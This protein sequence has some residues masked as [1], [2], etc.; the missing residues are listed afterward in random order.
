MS[1]EYRR[2]DHGRL[3]DFVAAAYKR[4]GLPS[5]DAVIAAEVMVHGDLM[6]IDSHGVAHLGTHFGYAPGLR[7]GTIKANPQ[8]RVVHETPSTA[9]IDGDGGLG[10]VVA[11]RAMEIAIAK[12]AQV[13]VGAVAVTNSRHYGAALHYAMMALPHDMIGISMTNTVP[14]VLPTF[15][16][17]RMLGT[18][19]ISVAAPAGQEPPFLLDMATS[20]VAGGKLE[21]AR[22]KGE[23]IP[24]GWAVDKDGKPTNDPF[25]TRQGGGLLPLGST[26]ELSSYKGYGLAVLVDIL[27]GV[28][29]GMGYSTMLSRTTGEMGHFF[30]AFRIDAF[31]PAADFKAMMDEMM[32]ALRATPPVEGAER[33]LVPGEKEAEAER[34]RLAKGIPLHP[35]VVSSLGK[36]ALEI[37]IQAE[38][39][40]LIS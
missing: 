18:N 9:L 14:S 12:A 32:R 5:E 20:V 40:A 16:R 26:P 33:V 24:F 4:L 35:D 25:V 19:P 15:G 11:H 3:R 30:A 8:I 23:L 36:L 17:E 39:Q 38:F 1:E 31:R 22:R 34:E 28:L 37:D 7:N 29:S 2:F 27:C 10:L 6:G 21:L 13:G